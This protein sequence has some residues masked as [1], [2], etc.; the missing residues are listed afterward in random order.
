VIRADE[1]T[2][3]RSLQ[4][5]A[6]GQ[7]GDGLVRGARRGVAVG[8]VFRRA[9]SFLFI[10]FTFT[11][12]TPHAEHRHP[13]GEAKPVAAAA[14]RSR[15]FVRVEELP[16][17]RVQRPEDLPIAARPAMRALR[18]REL[19]PPLLQAADRLLWKDDPPLGTEVAL[20]VNHKEY[21]ARME[22]HYHDVGGRARPWGYHKGVT[23]YAAE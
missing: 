9:S 20:N 23:L 5:R 18:A 7:R 6:W 10:L 11:C 22:L 1:A 2:A 14:A 12:S 15:R 4:A 19:T 17:E 8:T 13:S 21:I 16:L 3:R